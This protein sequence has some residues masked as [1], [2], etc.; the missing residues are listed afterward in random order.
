MSK[1]YKNLGRLTKK[2]KK[3]E[4]SG[5]QSK[6]KEKLQP[7]F[8]RYKKIIKEYCEQAICPKKLASTEK[9]DKFL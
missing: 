9:V 6:N 1:I 7:I 2:K 3:R 8:Q 5:K 4:D